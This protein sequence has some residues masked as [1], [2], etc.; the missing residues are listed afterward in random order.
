M[1]PS[2][3]ADICRRLHAIPWAEPIRVQFTCDDTPL[4][5]CRLCILRYGLKT[6]DRTRLFA[7]ERDALSHTCTHPEM[8]AA[9]RAST[10]L[11]D[12]L[13]LLLFANPFLTVRASLRW[14]PSDAFEDGVAYGGQGWLRRRPV[15]SFFPALRS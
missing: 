8:A 5:G 7:D 3:V 6:G 12:L 11:A 14:W 10:T 13:T 1:P 9:R 4:F 15:D 2:S